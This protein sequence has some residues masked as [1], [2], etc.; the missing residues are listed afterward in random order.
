MALMEAYQG[1]LDRYALLAAMVERQVLGGR[2]TA[3]LILP[4]V[5]STHDEFCPGAVPLQR[6]L[7]YR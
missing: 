5:V 6:G 4:V 3:P 7:L 1:T 2:R